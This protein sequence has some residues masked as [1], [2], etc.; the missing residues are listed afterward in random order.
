VV[1]HNTPY[2]LDF[3]SKKKYGLYLG[4]EGVD[5]NQISAKVDKVDSIW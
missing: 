2:I 4:T 5:K 1:Q 3:F